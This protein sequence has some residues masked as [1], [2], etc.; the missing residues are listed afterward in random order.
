MVH[1][2][3]ARIGQVRETNHVGI[4]HGSEENV[5]E[6]GGHISDRLFLFCPSALRKSILNRGIVS[7]ALQRCRYSSPEA[8]AA[9]PCSRAGQTDS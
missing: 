2:A 1:G 4:A 7:S 3:N 5:S 6:R 8:L 9:A